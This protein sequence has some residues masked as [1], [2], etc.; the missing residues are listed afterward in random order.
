MKNSKLIMA[1][2]IILSLIL[3]TGLFAQDEKK[4]NK[5][6]D[7]KSEIRIKLVLGNCLIKKSNND[8]INV[9]LV[10]TYSDENF[11]PVFRERS[12]YI[13]MKEKFHGDNPR[14]ESNWTIEIPED[15]E[16]DFE[17]A[18]GDLVI[19]N[20]NVEIDGNTGTGDIEISGAAGKY[21]LNTGT[22]RIDMTDS[23]GDFDLNSGTGRINVKGSEGEFKLNSG[24]GRVSAKNIKGNIKLNSGTG[25]VEAGN[26]TIEDEGSFNSG[27]GDA[28]VISPSG[29]NYELTVS[30]GTGSATLDMNGKAIEGNFEF[31]AHARKGRIDSPVKFDNEEEYYE[32]DTKYLRKSFTKGKKTPMFYI[33][34]GTGKAKLKR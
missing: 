8:K 3:T 28:E 24:T 7:K 21:D 14:G 13:E 34:T 15:M 22:G 1:L 23:E 11:E 5:T 18:T 26:I 25:D 32:H 6:F 27:T 12:G 29:N 19:E 9:N 20:V 17:S 30:S 4:V 16:I 31:T 33:S 2:V 10:Y